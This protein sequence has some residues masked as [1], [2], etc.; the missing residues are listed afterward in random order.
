MAVAGGR[1]AGAETRTRG[2]RVSQSPRGRRDLYARQRS[3]RPWPSRPLAPRGPDCPRR[4]PVAPPSTSALS[5]ASARRDG[6]VP[7]GQPGPSGRARAGGSRRGVARQHHSCPGPLRPWAPGTRARP[8]GYAPGVA[9]GPGE[10]D[11]RGEADERGKARTGDLRDSHSPGPNPEPRPQGYVLRPK[12]RG[13]GRASWGPRLQHRSPAADSWATARPRGGRRECRTTRC[14][15]RSGPRTAT[16][17]AATGSR[18]CTASCGTRGGTTS[19][20]NARLWHGPEN[21][22]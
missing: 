6:A 2:R 16:K 9:P 11:E 12:S 22:P 21:G 1:S 3:Q 4:T 15:A 20:S 18:E 10:V 14:T 13:S 17:R 19:S 5:Q 7:G 8:P